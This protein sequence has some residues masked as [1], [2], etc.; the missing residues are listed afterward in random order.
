[1]FEVASLDPAH[2]CKHGDFKEDELEVLKVKTMSVH[3]L[4][5]KHNIQEVDLLMLD[6]E[7]MD[8]T[9]LKTIDFSKYKIHRLIFENVHVK[10]EGIF[11]YLEEQGFTIVARNYGPQGWNTF[12]VHN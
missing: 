5:E 1:M 11:E 9:I 10:D 2:V 6:T 7:G 4:F 3:S 12:A 8:D